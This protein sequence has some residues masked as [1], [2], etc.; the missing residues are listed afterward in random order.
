ML[1]AIAL[2]SNLHSAFGPPD[3]NLREALRRLGAL[4]EVKAVSS[5]LDTAPVGLLEQ[6][7]FTN[8]AALLET[9]LGPLDL[10]RALLEVERS[11]GRRRTADQPPKGPRIIDLDLLLYED[12]L[13]R[14]RVLHDPDLTLP[15]PE[16]HRRLFVL[17]PLAE[18]APSM[19]D[20]VSGKTIRELLER[21][22]LGS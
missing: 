3:A 11:M 7:R 1:A 22:R 10:L 13:G 12:S 9:A 4:G 8:A 14:S 16:L 21:L 20:P 15:H 6:P 19:L 18:I 17:E 2:G 5:F